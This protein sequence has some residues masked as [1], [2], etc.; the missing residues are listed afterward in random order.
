MLSCRVGALTCWAV[1][2]PLALGL[3]LGLDFG[4]PGVYAA[5]ALAQLAAFLWTTRLFGRKKWLEYGLRKRHTAPK[6]RRHS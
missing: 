3:G 1:G 4:A 5:S 6:A 2:I